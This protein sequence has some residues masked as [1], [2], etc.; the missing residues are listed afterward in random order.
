MWHSLRSADFK[1]VPPNNLRGTAASSSCGPL[2]ALG[3]LTR[4]P[5]LGTLLAV[6]VPVR[7]SAFPDISLAGLVGEPSLLEGPAARGGGVRCDKRQLGFELN[8]DAETLAPRDATTTC[9]A[10]STNLELPSIERMVATLIAT[11]LEK[12]RER[13]AVG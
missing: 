11:W 9:N 5:I 10:V 13:K 4:T 7:E 6:G 12:E 1:N 2:Q 8:S 3:A